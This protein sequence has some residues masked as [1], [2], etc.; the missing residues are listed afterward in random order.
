MYM[1][2]VASFNQRAYQDQE[3]VP[4]GPKIEVTFSL[5]LMK[6]LSVTLI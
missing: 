1:Y 2:H 4:I 5:P 6:I 3:M